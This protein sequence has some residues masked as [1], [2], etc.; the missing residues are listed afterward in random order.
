MRKIMV[1]VC[2]F[3]CLCGLSAQ[4]FSIPSGAELLESTEIK[5][6]GV[7]YIVE[8]RYRLLLGK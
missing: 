3:V 8:Q 1:V 2:F 6:N 7:A 5:D 4:Q